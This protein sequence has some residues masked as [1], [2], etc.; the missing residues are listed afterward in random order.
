MTSGT[1]ELGPHKFNM[2]LGHPPIAVMLATFL[3]KACRRASRQPLDVS[4]PPADVFVPPFSICAPELCV[5]S[6][7]EQNTCTANACCPNLKVCIPKG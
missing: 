2:E 5:D 1:K 7:T 3:S 4:A 6:F